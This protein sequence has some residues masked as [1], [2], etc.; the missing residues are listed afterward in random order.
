MKLTELTLRKALDLAADTE[1]AAAQRYQE[2]AR[3]FAAS[4]EV[5]EVFTQLASDESSHEAHFRD[6][7]SRVREGEAPPRGE[8]SMDLVRASVASE[9][10]KPGGFAAAEVKTPADALQKALGLERATL[11]FYISLQDV[12]GESPEL[13]HLIEAEKRH[14]TTLMKVLLSDA[15]F[16]S[17]DDTW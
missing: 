13:A 1:A 10:F 17:L 7:A 5:A 14:V 11:F 16:R 3:Q 8:D 9:F 12:M 4:P 15:K 2:L 6:V